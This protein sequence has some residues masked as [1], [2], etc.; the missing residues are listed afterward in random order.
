MENLK[1]NKRK[2][3]EDNSTANAKRLKLD[4]DKIKW[5]IGDEKFK[6][7]ILKYKN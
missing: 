3:E 2:A 4:K 7:S 5:D 6:A 1:N